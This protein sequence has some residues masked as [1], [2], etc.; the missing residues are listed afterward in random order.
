MAHDRSSDPAMNKALRR[1]LRDSLEAAGK[2]CPEASILAAYFDRELPASETE[3]WEGHFSVCARCQEQLA[4]LA[5]TEP[6]VAETQASEERAGWRAFWRLRWLA[7]MA[8]AAAAAVLWILIRPAPP[9]VAPPEATMAS[10]Q[11]AP[12]TAPPAAKRAAE[13]DKVAKVAEAAEAEK[14][15]LGDKRSLPAKPAAAPA[16]ARQFARAPEVAVATVEK[17]EAEKLAAPAPADAASRDRA[18]AVVV[19]EAAQDEMKAQRR[20]EAAGAPAAAMRSKV[21]TAELQKVTPAA[22]GPGRESRG[23][24]ATARFTALRSLQVVIVS[25]N[26]S[27]LWRFGVEGLIEK[28]TDA[29]KTWSRQANPAQQNLFAGSAPAEK[30]CWGVGAQGTVV[31]TTDGELWEK[32]ASPTTENLISVT[33]R[34]ALNASVT[35]SSGKTFVTTDGGKTWREE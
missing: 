18:Q 24:A 20:D 8:T 13:A 12:A 28:S 4:I 25:P 7:P 21:A 1:S 22:P 16:P 33:A 3:R 26:R 2:D 15:N 31:R 30:I 27:V 6:A 29:G 32:I 35:S 5:R 9:T 10:R 14:A 23:Q 17:K 11:A 19:A 34:D